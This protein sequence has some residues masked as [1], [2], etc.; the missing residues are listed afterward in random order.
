VRPINLIPEEQRRGPGAAVTRT[1]PVAY[2]LVGVLAVA[3]IGVVMLVL[4]SNQ[5]HTR[6]A[7]VARL[8][9]EKA[10]ATSRATQLSAYINF[11][12]VSEDRTRTVAELADT[13]FD[14]VRVIHQL[15]LVLPG[16]VYFERMIASGGGGHAEASVSGPS[17]ALVGCAQGQ[18]AVAGFV[19]ALKGIDGVTRVEL[20]NSTLNEESKR[21]IGPCGR[22]GVANFKML[23]AFDG[24]PPSPDSAEGISEAEAAEEE[25]STAES[26]GSEEEGAE[27]ESSS[28][29]EESSSQSADT[30]TP[31]ATG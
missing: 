3:L 24:A 30:S 11:K 12:Q 8:E 7:E 23:V 19:A 22:A 13:R 15:S 20:G 14:W 27:S 28:G 25:S 26:E 9:N 10:A 16:D 31:G 21:E 6:E 18:A 29:G 5:V 17:M 1:G 2:V 4:L